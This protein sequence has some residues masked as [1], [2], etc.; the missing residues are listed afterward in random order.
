M[1]AC[2]TVRL[3]SGTT[4]IRIYMAAI[5]RIAQDGSTMGKQCFKCNAMVR[6]DAP[7]CLACGAPFGP[8]PQPGRTRW[9]LT[10]ITVVIVGAIVLVFMV[11]KMR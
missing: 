11:T 8:I 4:T 7:N 10:V 1:L 3:P 5:A 2:I 6:D 9:L